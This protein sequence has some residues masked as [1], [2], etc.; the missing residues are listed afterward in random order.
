MSDIASST[1]ARAA[2]STNRARELLAWGTAIT[3]IALAMAWGITVLVTGELTDEPHNVV[4]AIAAT[5]GFAVVGAMIAARTGN[6]VGWCL[7]GVTAAFGV[8]V[9]F[10]AYATY[11]YGIAEEPLPAGDVAAWI[12][13]VGFSLSL[14]FIGAIPILFPDGRPRWRWLWIAYRVAMVVTLAGFSIL[15]GRLTTFTEAGPPNP[16][17]VPAWE[18]VVGTI[19]A[20]SGPALLAGSFLG[21][22]SVIVRYRRAR[23]DERQQ[24][25]WFVYVGLIATV[26]VAITITIEVAFGQ[27]RT[28]FEAFLV[29]LSSFVFF[30]FLLL[31]IPAA[32]GVS[33][34]KYHLYDLD[35]VFRK[36][37]VAGAMAVLF[38]AVYAVVVGI[39]SQLFD[40]TALSFVAAAGLALAFQPV[41]TRTR[42]L[43]DRF[44]YGS[45]ATPYEV[46]SR[47]TAHVGEEYAGDDLL[48][49]MVAVL[50][51]GTGAR[52]A[53]VWLHVGGEM[54]RAASWPPDDSHPDVAPDD[55]VLVLDRG[56][57]LG[58]L[59]VEMPASDPLDPTRERL[60]HDL[61][62]QAGLVLRNVRLIEELRASRQRLVA[63]QDQERRKIERNIHDGAQQQLV[64]ISVKL[65]L[66]QQLAERDPTA[67]AALAEQLRDD[68]T[69]ALDDLRDL[70]RG[71]YPPV[72]ADSGLAAA[73]DAQA[74]RSVLRV[75]VS[76]DGI[77][78]YP[79]E[80]ESAIYF[81]CLEALQNVAKYA[82]ATRVDL[83]LSQRD[84][85][86]VF[87]IEDDGRGFDAATAERGSGLQGMADRLDA[88]GGTLDVR[89]SPGAGT[90]VIG[91]AKVTRG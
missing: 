5:A 4:L 60:V 81:C 13:S 54:R 43:V 51:N 39:G 47:F 65:R 2:R 46:L 78:R 16:F 91:S 86:I 55:A 33:I 1:E 20:V 38:T 62:S 70:A 50:G 87:E 61:A 10:G 58:A 31:G 25:R 88:I 90:T 27:R 30:A 11:S 29:D 22:V 26:L 83:R 17:A 14:M 89:S 63:A 77:G 71:I 35:L 36:T 24:I 72:L 69:Q 23:G 80:I 82:E 56:E 68:A 32:I 9:A 79:Q 48:D 52:S 8:F 6:A 73:L 37:L 66:L 59:S 85:R 19:L 34:L 15:P 3:S 76:A 41:L 57:I 74:R 28:S 12:A 7:L 49:R 75:D 84:G 45:R 64:A 40:S 21:V 67:A 53:S 44:V 18:D 42:R